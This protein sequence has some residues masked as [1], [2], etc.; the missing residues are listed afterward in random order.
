MFIRD[1]YLATILI[2]IV[3]EECMTGR[4]RSSPI[5]SGASTSVVGKYKGKKKVSYC[6]DA[7][8]DGDSSGSK[9]LDEE[10]G[11]PLVRTPCV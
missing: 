1:Y 6:I 5:S 11:I 10:L 9:S 4:L 7:V 2:V 8:L 3:K